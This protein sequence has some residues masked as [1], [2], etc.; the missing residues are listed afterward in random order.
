MRQLSFLI[1]AFAI[2][3]TT[4]AYTGHAPSTQAL[5]LAHQF[6]E[7]DL[8]MVRIDAEKFI[9]GETRTPEE[10][11]RAYSL[12]SMR[13]QT[14]NT[15]VSKNTDFK[16]ATIC[17]YALDFTIPKSPTPIQPAENHMP[18]KEELERAAKKISRCIYTSLWE[19]LTTIVSTEDILSNAATLVS[20]WEEDLPADE[21]KIFKDN[22]N[23][24]I[25]KIIH[26]TP[27]ALEKH[28]KMVLRCAHRLEENDQDNQFIESVENKLALS[29]SPTT[30]ENYMIT[31]EE[32]YQS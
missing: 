12:A 32:C 21:L 8:E 16:P 6:N 25:S 4:F 9:I 11:M 19:D 26:P 15:K 30:Y 2:L 29:L 18:I 10:K 5:A 3:P 23:A 20:E 24:R 28:V 31:F 17:E 22:L 27:Q 14:P 7:L 13:G 1:A